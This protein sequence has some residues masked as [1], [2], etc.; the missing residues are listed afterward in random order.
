MSLVK[1]IF[2]CLFWALLFQLGLIVTFAVIIVIVPVMYQ[3]FGIV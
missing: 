3:L 2:K 1:L